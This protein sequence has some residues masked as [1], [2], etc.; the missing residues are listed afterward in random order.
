MRTSPQAFADR[1]GKN[2]QPYR[3]WVWRVKILLAA[4]T[5]NFTRCRADGALL[6]A[7]VVVLDRLCKYLLD[8]RVEATLPSAAVGLLWE[9]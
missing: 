3:I 4:A 1:Q 9:Q 6:P 8:G 2:A 7:E 5:R